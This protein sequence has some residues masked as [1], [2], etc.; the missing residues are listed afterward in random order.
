D[1]DE[2]IDFSRGPFSDDESSAEEEERQQDDDDQK[3][4]PHLLKKPINGCNDQ[5]AIPATKPLSDASTL[6]DPDA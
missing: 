2:E 5:G 6:D 3:I 1:S 4:F